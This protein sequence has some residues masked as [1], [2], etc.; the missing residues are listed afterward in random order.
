MIAGKY[1]FLLREGLAWGHA[2]ATPLL[3]AA[4][5]CTALHASSCTLF[6]ALRMEFTASRLL[7]GVAAARDKDF[8]GTLLRKTTFRLAELP[9]PSPGQG[10][11][12]DKPA[13]VRRQIDL[14][15]LHKEN[16]GGL[17]TCGVIPLV[18]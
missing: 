1:A 7:P 10:L 9:H 4:Y 18:R 3:S 16:F 5:G 2:A 15:H 11:H 14:F 13:V 6:P 12:R 8:Q 17:L